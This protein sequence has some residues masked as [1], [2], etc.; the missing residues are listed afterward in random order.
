MSPPSHNT[1]E[2][3]ASVN[4]PKL[5]AEAGPA[6]RLSDEATEILVANT[7]QAHARRGRHR[8]TY[9]LQLA[10][11]VVLFLSLSAAVSAAFLLRSRQLQST[12]QPAAHV[13]QPQE[14]PAPVVPATPEPPRPPQA[15]PEPK[16]ASVAP[17]TSDLLA[18][19]NHL[20]RQARWSAAARAYE[21]AI[22][23][24]PHSQNAYAAMVAAGSL[25][26]DRLRDP[27]R[28]AKLFQSA[29]ALQPAGPLA[30]E[31]RWGL[32]QAY[33]SLGN[34]SRERKALQAFLHHHPHSALAAQ[35]QARLNR[36]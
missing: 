33:R 23:S 5:D 9:I 31:A 32:A 29:L 20:R 34:Q 15:V 22:R 28:G 36:P 14:M 2:P 12:R 27:Q 7:L 11:G 24:S 10:A 17:S 19:A 18:Q 4:L 21:R 13:S 3:W 6:R 30:E 35:A 26:V 8:R 16:R 25:Y 1:P